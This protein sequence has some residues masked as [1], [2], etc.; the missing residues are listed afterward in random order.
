VAGQHHGAVER[1]DRERLGVETGIALEGLLD[2]VPD[3]GGRGVGDGQLDLVAI[4]SLS[5]RG[6]QKSSSST[7]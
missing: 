3:V 4:A 6:S 1:V 5:T 2:R 7:S